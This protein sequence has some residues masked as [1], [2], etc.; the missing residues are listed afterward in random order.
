MADAETVDAL[1][2]RPRG[3]A[4]L[5]R[6]LE[7][8]RAELTGY[9][10][11]MLGSAFEA[12]D[13]VQDT[14]VRAWRSFDRFE[15]R[16]ALR[17]WL[18][19]IATNVC[20]DMLKGRERR[21]RP[22]DLGPAREPDRR[23]PAHA[24]GGHLDR[25]DAR[26][27]RR[28]GG[29]PG[30]RRGRARDDPARVR[31]RPPAPAA[32]A[33]G[34]ADPVRG[35]AL[36]GVGGRR[37]PRDERRVGQQ[38]APAGARDPRRERRDA[39]REPLPPSTRP[40]PS[41][42]P[43]T[44]TR[45]SATTWTRSRADPRGRDAVDAAVRPVAERPRRHLHLVG[46]AGSGLPRL[47]GGPDD[48]GER[49][50]RVRAVQAEPE[51]ARATS[52][53]RCR[54]SSSRTAGSSSSPSSS[55][56]RRSSRCSACRFGSIVGARLEQR[57]SGR[58]SRRPMKTSRS[59]SSGDACRS[60]TR[61]PFRRA[62][63]CSRASASTVT[64]SGSTPATSQTAAPAPLSLRQLTDALGEP[65]QVGARDRPA[66]RERD[67]LRRCGHRDT[68]ARREANSSVCSR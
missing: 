10:Y 25:A 45:S 42:S 68:D 56:P 26:R 24:A 14:L 15:G 21:A 2:S 17:S 38:R 27:P 64:A 12:E 40:T 35:A 22:M 62:P 67:R 66:N 39:R 11:R 7:Q 9:C 59:S 60:R 32:A 18:Y 28:P 50:A 54:C 46:R 3:A 33:A 4:E 48:R 6:R 55:T 8:H 65:G 31:R 23:Q 52:R 57:H 1:T 63:S 49:L 58:T 41:C 53:G 19:R 47:A 5:E 20:L 13:A 37:A 29:R 44:W 30:G 16:A 51:P 36:A 34:G 43:A 61:H